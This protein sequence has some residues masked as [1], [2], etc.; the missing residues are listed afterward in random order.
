M[1]GK[2]VVIESE[3]EIMGV[4]LESWERFLDELEGS[5][6]KRGKRG[7]VIHGAEWV[8]MRRNCYGV[9]AKGI[10]VKKE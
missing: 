5:R 10:L 2:E 9:D 8:A 7:K 1:V 3:S 4:G 6:G